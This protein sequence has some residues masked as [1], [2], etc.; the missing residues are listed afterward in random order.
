M[1]GDYAFPKTTEDT[2]GPT[3]LVLRVYPYKLVSACIVGAKGPDPPVVERVAK[4]LRDAGLVHFA[5]R[6]NRKPAIRAL[7]EAACNKASRSKVR[8]SANPTP[9]DPDVVDDESEKK[10]DRVLVGVPEHSMPG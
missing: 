6:S 1:V 3:M 9:A 8:E 4:F 2:D 10:S 5:Y 7:L